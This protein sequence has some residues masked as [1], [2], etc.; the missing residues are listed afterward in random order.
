[1]WD[2]R[3]GR[4]PSR[5]WVQ[6]GKENE[7]AN[8]CLQ[9]ERDVCHRK[10]SAGGPHSRTA[11]DEPA[12]L[13]TL[14]RQEPAQSLRARGRVLRCQARGSLVPGQGSRH[15]LPEGPGRS[16]VC[17]WGRGWG[18]C[19]GPGGS[20]SHEARE[21]PPGW[22]WR[23]LVQKD[24]EATASPRARPA[25]TPR[26]TPPHPQAH[27]SAAAAPGSWRNTLC[28][29]TGWAQTPPRCCSPGCLQLHRSG[30][31]RDAQGATPKPAAQGRACP[32]GAGAIQAG[33]TA[34]LSAPLPGLHA[35]TPSVPRDSPVSQARKL[36]TDRCA[37]AA[38]LRGLSQSR[39]RDPLP[40]SLPKQ[41]QWEGR[42][43]SQ[44]FEKKTPYGAE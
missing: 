40:P 4:V 6:G 43:P 15:Q 5:S 18:L 24:R 33:S 22:P 23:P 34:P 10:G 29:P 31:K 44:D 41:G 28:T 38:P 11:S 2:R 17:S 19:S 30:G 21:R 8:T 37:G 25:L 36:S 35:R 3:A 1:M 26:R 7:K 32:P 14:E 42:I 20:C 16:R 27:R 39:E 13:N 12:R 9:T